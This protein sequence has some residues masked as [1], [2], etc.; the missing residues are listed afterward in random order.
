MNILIILTIIYLIIVGYLIYEFKKETIGETLFGM[1]IILTSLIYI[2][3]LLIFY[4]NFTIKNILKFISVI[5]IFVP[6]IITVILESYSV[7]CY[8]KSI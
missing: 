8:I 2:S 6:V 4:F 5:I 7:T 3:M 1:Q